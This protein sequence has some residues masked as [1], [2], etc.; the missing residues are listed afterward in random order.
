MDGVDDYMDIAHDSAIDPRRVFTYSF[1]FNSTSQTKTW[2]PVLFKGNSSGQRT[3][4]FWLNSG[5]KRIHSVTV[6]A[7]GQ[8]DADSSNNFWSHNQWYAVAS[9]MDRNS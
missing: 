6:D 3:Y 8:Y 4:A 2:T 9:V 1:W 7:S 5:D